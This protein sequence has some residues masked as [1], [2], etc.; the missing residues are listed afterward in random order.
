MKTFKFAV[1]FTLSAAM[2]AGFLDFP[3]SEAASGKKRLAVIGVRNEINR[4]QWNNQLIGHGL[5]SLLSQKLCDTGQYVAIED[6]PEIIDR[7]QHLIRTQW[8]RDSKYYT[9]EDADRLALDL[10][11][12]AV[13]FARVIHFSTKR[14]RGFAGPFSGADTKVLIEVEVGIKEKGQ[15]VRMA[16]GKG[17]AST[18]SM[19]T[20]FHI[21]EDKVY[22]DETT[23]GKAAHRAIDDAIRELGVK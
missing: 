2:V 8:Q 14:K 17:E 13:A 3:P 6:N 7:I 21:R 9:S 20:F 12:D 18:R 5:S 19:G 10:G 16:K 23:V 4:P 22:F 1:I 15:P 11:S